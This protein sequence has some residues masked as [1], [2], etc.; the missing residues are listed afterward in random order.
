MKTAFIVLTYN[1]ADAL[2]AVLRGLAP[3][4]GAQ[5]EVLIAD[6]GSRAD[7]VEAMRAGL[8]AF[9]CRVRHIWHPDV[10]FTIARA[11]NLCAARTEAD[12]L[13][14]IDGDCVPNAD[15][16]AQHEQLA[17]PGQFVIGGRVLLEERLTQ[18]VLAGQVDLQALGAADWLRL[19]LT[20][21]ANKL[22]QLLSGLRARGTL[23]S[24]FRWK[25]I[26]GCNMAFWR[27]DYEA[28]NGFDE[29]FAG[30]GHEDADIVLRLHQHG[31]RRCNA[32]IGTEVFH[33]WHRQNSRADEGEN[34]R[35]VM[36]RLQG[37]MVQAERGV[38]QARI[39]PEAIET[40][41]IGT[42]RD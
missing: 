4:C 10:G 14:F 26:R 32:R 2:L 28:V 38:A 33:L 18:R 29:A 21:Q 24:A 11:R 30:W 36:D 12:Y 27:A 23:E 35:R 39:S 40:E 15:F 22:S 42:R 37:G 1:R 34:R 13:V 20:G 5:H 16:V 7:Q 3:Q 31:L 8:P 17:W 41:L 25:G 6:D 19:R 9:Q